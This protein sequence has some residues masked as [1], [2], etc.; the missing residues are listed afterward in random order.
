MF[1]LFKSSIVY[2][3]IYVDCIE[4]RHITKDVS[5]KRKA[6]NKFSSERLLIADFLSANNFIRE[7]LDEI[8]G[9][10]FF[11]PSMWA[12]IQPMEKKEGGL[13]QV[14]ER[15]FYDLM[16][17]AGAVRVE[18]YDKDDLLADETVKALFD[19]KSRFTYMKNHMIASS[20]ECINFKNRP[21]LFF[22]IIPFIFLLGIITFSLYFILRSHEEKFWFFMT[23]LFFIIELFFFQRLFSKLRYVPNG[24]FK[25]DENGI[26]IVGSR[27]NYTINWNQI[28]NLKIYYRGDHFWK[29]RIFKY[30][31][32]TK[33]SRYSNLKWNFVRKLDEQ[34]LDCIDINNERFYIK[35]RNENEKQIL[36]NLF[37]LAKEKVK[38]MNLLQ[39]P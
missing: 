37:T 29:I 20:L 11:K 26:S 36:M 3:K 16:E 32:Y 39:A 9:K 1:Q 22:I 38:N 5:I 27:T 12:V 17:Q 2:F 7:L 10:K 30:T 28:V 23:F 4:V 24:S 14:E 8:E 6:I 13:S 19:K 18:I 34:M 33:G 21:W 31:I 35:I 15:A 25:Y